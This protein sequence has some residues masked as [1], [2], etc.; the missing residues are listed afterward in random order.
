MG[1]ET[2]VEPAVL[3]LMRYRFSTLQ[4]LGSIM[5]DSGELIYFKSTSKNYVIDITYQGYELLSTIR[6]AKFLRNIKVGI[7]GLPN[8]TI[9]A[10]LKMFLY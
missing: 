3:Q 10:F 8:S 1:A 6:Y 7:N 9:K 4:Y 2:G 5:V